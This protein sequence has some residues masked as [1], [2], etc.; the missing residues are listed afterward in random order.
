MSKG[1]PRYRVIYKNAKTGK[2][3][4]SI[5]LTKARAEEMAA[6]VKKL[7]GGRV[8]IVRDRSAD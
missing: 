2:P 4:Q 8:A 1:V 3:V 7:V 5:P 6:A